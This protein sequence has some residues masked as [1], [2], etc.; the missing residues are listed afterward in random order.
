M[1]RDGYR[2]GLAERWEESADGLRLLLHL[3]P[4]VRWHDGHPLG[5]VDVQASLEP[6]LRS[7]SRQPALRALLADIEAVE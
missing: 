7:S 1:R 5:P 4:G 2:P 3:R 6:L